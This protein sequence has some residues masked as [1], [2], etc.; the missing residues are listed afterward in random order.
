MTNDIESAVAE[1]EKMGM[2]LDEWFDSRFAEKMKEYQSN[3]VPK[4]SIKVRK[5]NLDWA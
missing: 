4:L 1:V 3:K 2:T 5:G